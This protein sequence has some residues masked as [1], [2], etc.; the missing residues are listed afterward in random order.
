MEKIKHNVIRIGTRE[1][2]LAVWQAQQVSNMFNDYLLANELHFI[3]SDG[4]INLTT[5]L[6]ELGV[7]G[8]FT[9]ALDIALLNNN[10]DIAVHSFKDI[11]TRLAKGLT[12]AAVLKRDNPFDMLVCKNAAA[13]KK[14]IENLPVII[15]T[16]S[17]RRKAQWLYKYNNTQIENIRGNVNT[18]LQKLQV[19]DWDAAIFAA[20]GL[21][22]LNITQK[23]SG[24]APA[25]G[26][27]AVVC[28]QNDEKVIN[29]CSV[30]NDECTAICT[31]AEREFLRLLKGGCATPISAYASIENNIIK[32]EANI[33]A[34]DGASSITVNAACSIN[35]YAALAEKTVTAITEKGGKD[36]LNN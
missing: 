29:A 10:I 7:Q 3:K 34:A 16:S 17:I 1:S 33:T 18:R 36:L 26:A 31:K 15:A 23:I 12:I 28:R 6:Y 13:Q 11:P 14:V 8:I 9:K 4:D 32:M 30:L 20:A 25:Q 19:S 24:P 35:E 5:P 27:V 2:A 21:E 22:R